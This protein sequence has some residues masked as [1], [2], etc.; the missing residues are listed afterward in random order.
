M[1]LCLDVGNT[2]ILGGVY[3]EKVLKMRFRYAT[4]LIGTADQF[5]IFIVSVLAAN[6][7]KAEQISGVSISSVVP[8]C[9]YTIN[10][11]ILQYFKMQPFMLK[12]GVKTGLNIRYKNPNEVGA[13][14]IANAIGA[15]KKFPQQN[16]I[17]ID[18]GT[19][20]TLC[21]VTSERDYLGGAILPGMRLG[22]ESLRSNTAKLME[23]NIEAPESHVG[24]TT[25]ESIQAG[26][27]YG[28]MGALKELIAGTKAEVFQDKPVKV[29]GTGGFSQ[30]FRDKALFDVILPDLVLEG[31]GIAFEYNQA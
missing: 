30:L 1:L 24:R 16:L 3:D 18:M 25:R 27:Y 13:D 11:T 19:A 31:L 15:V 28:Q 14:R 12:A 21:T 10:H 9:D 29:I 8:S 20:T 4:P 23:V 5:G 6:Q 26:L 22:M 17:I 2:H 7:I